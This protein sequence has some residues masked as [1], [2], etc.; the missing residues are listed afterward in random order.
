MFDTR[1]E[2]MDS[3]LV[4]VRPQSNAETTSGNNALL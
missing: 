4:F 1:F 3:K 2:S